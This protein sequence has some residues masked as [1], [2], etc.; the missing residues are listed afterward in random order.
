VCDDGRNVVNIE[1][2]KKNAIAQG[3]V[4]QEIAILYVG[5]NDQE[6]TLLKALNLLKLETGNTV[7]ATFTQAGDALFPE[8]ITGVQYLAAD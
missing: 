1:E 6:K 7:I 8:K 3:V 4:L 5:L 2:I